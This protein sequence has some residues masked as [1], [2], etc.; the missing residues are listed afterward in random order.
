MRDYETG[1]IGF[2]I[3]KTDWATLGQENLESMSEISQLDF[4]PNR[5]DLALNPQSIT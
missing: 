2:K 1:N 5:L 4:F 3:G